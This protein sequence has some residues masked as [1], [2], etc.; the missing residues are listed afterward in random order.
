MPHLQARG[1]PHLEDTHIVNLNPVFM[2]RFLDLDLDHLHSAILDLL[3]HI[4][5][6]ALVREEGEVQQVVLGRLQPGEKVRRGLYHRLVRVM[7]SHWQLLGVAGWAWAWVW[8]EEDSSSPVW[9]R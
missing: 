2:D 1:L 7:E 9:Q 6:V 3:L 5:T 8:V 4:H